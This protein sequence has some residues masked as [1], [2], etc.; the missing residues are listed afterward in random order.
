MSP[1]VNSKAAPT[2]D[3]VCNNCKWSFHKTGKQYVVC[4]VDLPPHVNISADPNRHLCHKNYTC[5]F[6]RYK[7]A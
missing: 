4:G 3:A 6:H 7:D 1:K 2:E 5:A